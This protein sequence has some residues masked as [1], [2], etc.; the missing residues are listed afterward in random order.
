MRSLDAA[1]I[2]EVRV[3]D[4]GVECVAGDVFWG[5]VVERHA[6][7]VAPSCASP[8][9]AGTAVVIVVF[10]VGGVVIVVLG[11]EGGQVSVGGWAPQWGRGL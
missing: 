8:R 1:C 5:T 10:F 2:R 6:L 3:T 11:Y 4:D 7:F 9:C